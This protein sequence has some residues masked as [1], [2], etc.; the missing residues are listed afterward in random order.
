MGQSCC[1]NQS[2]YVRQHDESSVNGN[3]HG[4]SIADIQQ[5]T[6]LRNLRNEPFPRTVSQIRPSEDSTK[7]SETELD[8]G[9]YGDAYLSYQPAEEPK[10]ASKISRLSTRLGRLRRRRSHGLDDNFS[11]NFPRSSNRV[12]HQRNSASVQWTMSPEAVYTG[13]H[14][15]FKEGQYVEREMKKEI[16]NKTSS[17]NSNDKYQGNEKPCKESTNA[18]SCTKPCEQLYRVQYTPITEGLP[19][20]PSRAA[21]P[22]GGLKSQQVDPVGSNGD[23]LQ[24]PPRYFRFPFSRHRGQAQL[25]G[26]RSND[27]H[28]PNQIETQRESEFGR[29]PPRPLVMGKPEQTNGVAIPDET[30]SELDII[31]SVERKPPLPLP[32]EDNDDI[33]VHSAGPSYSNNNIVSSVPDQFQSSVST[34]ALSDSGSTTTSL[35]ESPSTLSTIEEV[36]QQSNSVRGPGTQS[37]THQQTDSSH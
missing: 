18:S 5:S 16:N 25:N 34:Q 23:E 28:H 29:D 7:G 35:Q 6:N 32:F 4:N 26:K 8:G 9:Y 19:A 30:P 37:N 13:G 33:S 27:R 12:S 17:A 11:N 21:S 20:P 36:Q 31:K 24:K 1:K 3:G 2:R 15:E 10:K 22:R 14:Q